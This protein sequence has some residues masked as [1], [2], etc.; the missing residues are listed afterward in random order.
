MKKKLFMVG[1]VAALAVGMSSLSGCGGGTTGPRL[2][3]A[4]KD[5]SEQMILTHL[6]AEMIEN[7]TEIKVVRKD[8]LG[9]TLVVFE[10]LKK[11]SI[12]MYIEYSG[13]AYVELLKHE[14]ISNP[15]LVYDV[16]STELEEKYNFKSLGQF[17]FNNTYVMTVTQDFATAH[18]LEK[19]S[20][21]VPIADQ[22]HG[23]FVF[24]FLNRQDGI[25]GLEETYGFEFGQTSALEGTLRY[26]SLVNGDI[27]ITSAFG[28]DS[29]ID[30]LGLVVL[31][32]D[33]NFFPP[34]YAFPL[35]RAE[36][37]EKYPEIIP[38]MAEL[39]EELSS[40]EVMIG[41]NSQVDEGQLEPRV[42]ARA[43]LL[44]KGLISE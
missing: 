27:N 20:D 22:L 4:G 35:L 10:A 44:E 2:V 23:G 29:L 8:N 3:V 18:N 25:I 28:T 16:S 36:T 40:E 30:K 17:G 42:V 9:G 31:E 32:D 26:T 41:L 12:D 38:L 13:T 19:V 6:V 11:G 1:A 14:P 37:Y 7:R 5:Y 43:F 15:Q 39:A 34:Y 24:E 21:L 33:L